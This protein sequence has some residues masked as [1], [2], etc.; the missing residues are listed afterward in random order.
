ME[1]LPVSGE[2]RE[3]AAPRTGHVA[4]LGALNVGRAALLLGAGRERKGNE[5]DPGAGVEVLVK[6]G[7]EVEAGQSVARLYGKRNAE[8][9]GELV[10]GALEVS[11]GPVERPP[12]ILGSL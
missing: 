12:A 2:A 1:N 3:V 7:D 4:R 8:R 5:I 9:A 6:V 11:D 10:L